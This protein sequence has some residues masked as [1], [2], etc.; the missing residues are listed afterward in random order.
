MIVCE[1]TPR[2]ARSGPGMFVFESTAANKCCASGAWHRVAGLMLHIIAMLHLGE[3]GQ[4]GSKQAVAHSS[5][6]KPAK[7][8]IF[9]TNYKAITAAFLIW[10]HSLYISYLEGG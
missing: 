7:A 8:S 10:I 2:V 9:G 4:R 6:R 5:G 3:C 1:H